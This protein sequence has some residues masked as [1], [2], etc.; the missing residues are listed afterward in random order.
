[1]WGQGFAAPLFS[2]EVEVLHQRLIGT[3]HS[4]FK[5]KIMGDVNGEARDAVR[6]GNIDSLPQRCRV[7]YRMGI[8]SYQGNNRLRMTIEAVEG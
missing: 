1:V 7:A 2:D 8:D 5:L 4:G 3:T 6:W